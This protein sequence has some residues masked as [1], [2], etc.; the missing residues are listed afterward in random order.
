M[1]CIFVGQPSGR[2]KQVPLVAVKPV[3]AGAASRLAYVALRAATFF[4]V[5]NRGYYI[6][7]QSGRNTEDR[8]VPW[9]IWL[10]FWCVFY[11]K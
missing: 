2:Q 5:D 7:C 10:G 4:S 9:I 8:F 3:R 6:Q 1:H 11:K